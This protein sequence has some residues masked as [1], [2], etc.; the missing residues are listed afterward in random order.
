MYSLI[1]IGSK[2]IYLYSTFLAFLLIKEAGNISLQFISLVFEFMEN[3][4]VTATKGKQPTSFISSFFSLYF[5]MLNQ[6][7]PTC[8]D[9]WE[10]LQAWDDGVLSFSHP[11][12]PL[13]PLSPYTT[14]TGV[15][16]YSYSSGLEPP[17][18][19]NY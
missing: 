11:P 8:K 1:H 13:P 18:A 5:Y 17:M 4:R 7:N 19:S 3:H 14:H 6:S 12:T 15:N 2:F 9:F 10:F 16:A